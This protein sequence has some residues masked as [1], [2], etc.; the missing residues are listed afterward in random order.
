MLVIK[1]VWIEK[2][3]CTGHTLCLPEAPGL[4]AYYASDDVS[5]VKESGLRHT[6]QELTLLLEASSV[7]PMRAFFIETEDGRVYGI[8]DHP[9]VR[10]AI[11][12]RSYRWSNSVTGTRDIVPVA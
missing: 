4:I 6:H 3:E 5:D 11:R 8:P 2:A 12:L 7:C 10:E 9:E 1:R